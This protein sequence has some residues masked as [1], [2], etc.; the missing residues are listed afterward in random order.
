MKQLSSDTLLLHGTRSAAWIELSQRPHKL[1][2]FLNLY[3]KE[4][5]IRVE[6]CDDYY[7][8]FGSKR[9]DRFDILP[10]PPCK[11]AAIHINAW[12]W[13]TLAGI[14]KDTHYVENYPY[15]E[16]PGSFGQAAVVKDLQ[17]RFTF[18]P[19]KEVD[20]RQMLF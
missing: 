9:R 13:H 17:E 20:I 12:Y 3:R 2:F 6:L 14:S 11:S 10:L 19:Q 1:P 16:N 5:D 4:N 18:R 8:H 15:P 7:P